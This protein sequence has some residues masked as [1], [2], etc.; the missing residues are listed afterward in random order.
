MKKILLL[1]ET[2]KNRV[3]MVSYELIARARRL[4]GKGE[5][6][7][8]KGGSVGINGID[9]SRG[10][11]V[12]KADDDTLEVVVIL[13]GEAENPEELC[14]RGADRVLHIDQKEFNYFSPERLQK[15]LSA[16]IKKEDP[17]VLIAAATTTGRTVM[18]YLAVK[19]KTGLT[20]DCTEL[21]LDTESGT[22]YQTR[23]AV[24]GN[25]MA[26]IKT[27]FG[28]PQMA[29][30]R[31]NS[32]KPLDR[33]ESRKVNIENLAFSG[34]ILK[35]RI[36]YLGITEFK[37]RETLKDAKVIISGGRGLKKKDNFFLIE[38]FAELIH[39]HA[40]ASREAVDRGWISYPHQVG[41]SGKTVNPELYVAVGISGAIQHLAGMQ[42]SKKIVSI[43]IDPG[44]QIFSVSD[45]GIVCDLFD[46]LPVVIKK[47]RGR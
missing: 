44:A 11:T 34:D 13:P 38:E 32:M 29:T 42:T 20:A 43:N 6:G 31:Q 33:D 25:I 24:G 10:I 21:K 1:G 47:L 26:T 16:I 46:I 2:K 9:R 28:K 15:A 39:A 18:P 45:L 30:V 35:S 4:P 8:K 3:K 40:G 41:L 5:V 12:G 37:E 14:Y 17:D 7:R 22:L 36:K 23:P 19:E 27:A